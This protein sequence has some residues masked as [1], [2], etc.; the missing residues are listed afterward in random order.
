[1]KE[2]IRPWGDFK[3]FVKNKKCTVKLLKVKPKQKLSLQYHRERGELW[4]FLTDGY[5]QQ[6]IDKKRVGR[7]EIV[8]IKKGQA[9][10]VFSKNK[11]ILFLEISF[12]KYS[13]KDEVRIE[14]AYGR[15]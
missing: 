11:S 5:V 1:M 12:G 6:G 14:D 15:E 7:G 2:V 10:R 8:F 9:H 4:Y 13:E 3:L